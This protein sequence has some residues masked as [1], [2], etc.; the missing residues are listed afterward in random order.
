MARTKPPKIGPHLF[1]VQLLH[2]RV[3]SFDEFPFCLP[4]I[5]K[6]KTHEDTEHY[7]VTQAFLATAKRGSA[8][9]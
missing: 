2:D 7:R 8:C 3:R 9:C 4:A 5:G 6:L 1:D